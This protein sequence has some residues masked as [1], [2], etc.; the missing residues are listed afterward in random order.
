MAS[1]SHKKWAQDFGTSAHTQELHVY[2]RPRGRILRHIGED[3]EEACEL[4]VDYHLDHI[5]AFKQERD[6]EGSCHTSPYP[7]GWSARKRTS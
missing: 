2:P 7:R 5:H 1:G 4:L 6:E 3:L